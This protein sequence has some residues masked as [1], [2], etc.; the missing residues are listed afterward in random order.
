[1]F[2]VEQCPAKSVQKYEK[3]AENERVSSEKILPPD[4][5]VR[6]SQFSFSN[7]NGD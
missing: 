7:N 2:H 1:M 3:E 6:L 4:K 5:W